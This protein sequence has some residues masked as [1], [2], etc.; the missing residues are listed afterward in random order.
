M[1]NSI[2]Q[3]AAHYRA[4][5]H[6]IERPLRKKS[7]GQRDRD[8]SPGRVEYTGQ[9]FAMHHERRMIDRATA[10]VRRA[11]PERPEGE[12]SLLAGV[13]LMICVAVVALGLAVLA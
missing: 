8:A 2:R 10:A 3:N 6:Q 4:A 11:I 5:S 9:F 12:P 13:G 7:D 1:T